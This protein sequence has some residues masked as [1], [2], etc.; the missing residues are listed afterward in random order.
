[1]NELLNRLKKLLE[2]CKF[3]KEGSLQIGPEAQEILNE[4]AKKIDSEELASALA[5]SFTFTQENRENEE[6]FLSKLAVVQAQFQE[7]Q[8][9]KI[10]LHQLLI[11]QSAFRKVFFSKHLYEHLGCLL[12]SNNLN[13]FLRKYFTELDHEKFFNKFE[14]YIQAHKERPHDFKKALTDKIYKRI[15]AVALNNKKCYTNDFLKKLTSFK[16]DDGFSFLCHLLTNYA[17]FR[18][19]FFTAATFEELKARLNL[20]P[21]DDWEYLLNFSA[22]KSFFQ[23]NPIFAD[24]F[25]Y[26]VPQ[27]NGQDFLISD[28]GENF[29]RYLGQIIIKA[30]K[31]PPA[32]YTEENL[33]RLSKIFTPNGISYLAL[34]LKQHRDFRFTFFSDQHNLLAAHIVLL[35]E[36]EL[37]AIHEKYPDELQSLFALPMEEELKAINKFSSAPQTLPADQKGK[38]KETEQPEPKIS[39]DLLLFRAG[40][41]TSMTNEQLAEKLP[42]FN[43]HLVELFL[44]KATPEQFEA[45]SYKLRLAFIRKITAAK[46][47]HLTMNWQIKFLKQIIIPILLQK[48]MLNQLILDLTAQ[49]IIPLIEA[50]EPKTLLH[51]IEVID[52]QAT[53]SLSFAQTHASIND[54]PI[55]RTFLSQE[56]FPDEIYLYIIE[57]IANITAVH[58]GFNAETFLHYIDKLRAADKL[59][60]FFKHLS[61][62]A[63]LFV[64]SHLVTFRRDQNLIEIIGQIPPDLLAAVLQKH[65]NTLSPISDDE[66]V[67]IVRQ[68]AKANT[69]SRETHNEC[70]GY[71]NIDQNTNIKVLEF[72]IR[73]FSRHQAE[74]GVLTEST[75]RQLSDTNKVHLAKLFSTADESEINEEYN[76][77]FVAPLLRPSNTK[78]KV[79]NVIN[80]LLPLLSPSLFYAQVRQFTTAK[81]K[82]I[83][84]WLL[85]AKYAELRIAIIQ[86]L[87]ASNLPISDKL[88][89]EPAQIPNVIDRFLLAK[90]GLTSEINADELDRLV[91]HLRGPLLAYAL[92][93][94]PSK[95]FIALSAAARKTLALEIEA[96]QYAIEV[97]QRHLNKLLIRPADIYREIALEA[98]NISFELSQE[99]FLFMAKSL[100]FGTFSETDLRPGHSPI[101]RGAILSHLAKDSTEITADILSSLDVDNMT[102]KQFAAFVT[103]ALDNKNFD[104]TT[105]LVKLGYGKFPPDQ[106]AQFIKAL[107]DKFVEQALLHFPDKVCKFS[108]HFKTYFARRII[109][110]EFSD[111]PTLLSDLGFDANAI[112]SYID[113]L[114]SS[115]LL[116]ILEKDRSLFNCLTIDG[117][118]NFI[119]RLVEQDNKTMDCTRKLIS[120]SQITIDLN[121]IDEG[122][123]KLRPIKA[124]CDSLTKRAADEHSG[125]YSKILLGKFLESCSEGGT[126][127][128]FKHHVLKLALHNKTV[129]EALPNSTKR[130]CI[131]NNYG[132]DRFQFKDTLIESPIEASFFTAIKKP[133]EDYIT[134]QT[135]SSRFLY[136]H[137]SAG[138]KENCI[139]LLI[140]M[141]RLHDVFLNDAAGALRTNEGK[142]ARDVALKA[143]NKKFLDALEDLSE[144]SDYVKVLHNPRGYF[145]KA[146]SCF[147]LGGLTDSAKALQKAVLEARNEM[148]INERSWRLK[149]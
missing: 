91:P 72:Y 57:K 56:N 98:K 142:A 124:L 3:T 35:S 52:Q 83:G 9:L 11:H 148:K 19:R 12:S 147:S 69:L 26:L 59:E 132:L 68:L 20:I 33:T 65:H 101:V 82:A 32:F 128:G 58:P 96:S 126:S 10:F 112:A 67:V 117:K 66:K 149:F 31:I 62:Q 15:T 21:K 114:S 55:I 4:I 146:R 14:R 135:N 70:L 143:V 27:V 138:K 103:T 50:L 139:K 108:L 8:P 42:S 116:S 94:I 133:I 118:T 61:P 93:I 122:I 79:G 47:N 63:T 5:Q 140:E 54:G 6:S 127:A 104:L 121:D 86:R 73:L 120:L 51:G 7:Q 113:E 110:G 145:Q 125:F 1:M 71:L 40:F 24:A 23:N 92:E 17:H 74:C 75:I 49:E 2:T 136:S 84:D 30:K 141:N 85:D 41:F 88:E 22:C 99:N 107:D 119:K 34:L 115:Q 95:T 80:N 13:F 43:S 44:S 100:P 53:T 60:V 111:K 78:E 64:I 102:P 130:L 37:H 45:F 46:N 89:V 76:S 144:S 16:L 48:Q 129:F 38:Q 29:A 81:C 36:E 97:Q 137:N 131:A 18:E 134:K 106:V 123:P 90:L 39:K 109:V 77:K 28:E 25:L 87:V 105:I